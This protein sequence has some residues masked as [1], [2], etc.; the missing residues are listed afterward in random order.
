MTKTTVRNWT[1]YVCESLV[2]AGTMPSWEATDYFTQ[3]L[4][5]EAPNQNLHSSKMPYE[6]ISQFLT[7]VYNPIVEAATRAVTMPPA[8]MIH[9]FTDV[10]L[11]G[12][13]AIL[14]VYF[15]GENRPHEL[16]L[17]DAARAWDVVFPHAEAFN[18]W[19]EERY[20]WV[21][22]A[23]SS[24]VTRTAAQELQARS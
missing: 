10:S 5:G 21:V 6:A 13:S 14:V 18:D 2:S 8:A 9:V 11:I 1:G 22:D 19:A 17:L 20:G 3:N 15:P 7:R 16:L 12:N 24:A 4:F 23:L